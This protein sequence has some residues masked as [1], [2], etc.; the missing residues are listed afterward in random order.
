METLPGETKFKLFCGLN[1]GEY[2]ALYKHL[3]VDRGDVLCSIDA[4]GLM[5]R[6]WHTTMS[7][8][9][10]EVYKVAGR[11]LGASMSLGASDSGTGGGGTSI[12]TRKR[13]KS[14]VS[15]PRL[16]EQA[17]KSDVAVKLCLDAGFRILE[18]E[19]DPATVLNLS[20]KREA[21]GSSVFR[22][23]FAGHS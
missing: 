7:E 21:W 1:E 2:R 10:L 3:V 9:L 15:S 19:V 4:P 23:S 16:V 12:H 22:V 20:V 14:R 11:T 6:T 18:V 8:A 13:Q 5:E 17:V